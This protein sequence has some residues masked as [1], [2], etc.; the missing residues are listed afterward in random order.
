M[1]AAKY[2]TYYNSNA[3]MLPSGVQAATIDAVEDNTLSI[4]WR[5]NGSG[6]NNVIPGETAVLLKSENGNY[7]LREV[8]GN[9][10]SA[11]TPNLLHG[12]DSEGTTTGGD[13]YYKLSY[14]P[15]NDND[16]KDKLGWYYGAENGAA[17]TI[18]AHKAWLALTTQQAQNARFF[19]LDGESGETTGI[20]AM[21]NSECIM[22]NEYFDLQGRKV[23]QP[24]KGL[25]IVN[26]KMVLI[27]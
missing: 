2:G 4:N 8:T 23:T 24:T 12:H 25:Y 14:G 1:S 16:L 13:K 19:S 3:T 5:Y 18:G 11:P 15:S 21:H 22:H 17:F 9:T 26:G 20:S 10:T 6:G 27:K 7:T